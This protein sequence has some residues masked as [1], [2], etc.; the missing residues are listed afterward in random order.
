M[1]SRL[2]EYFTEY[3]LYIVFETARDASTSNRE[4]LQQILLL[5]DGKFLSHMK[6]MIFDDGQNFYH[7]SWFTLTS[8]EL[9]K[10]I[11]LESIENFE[12][13]QIIEKEGF[14]DITGVYLADPVYPKKKKD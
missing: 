13:Y 1:P 6:V 8:L 5:S 11:A 3:V 7:Q 9:Y 14:I 10:V 12:I 2:H 4:I